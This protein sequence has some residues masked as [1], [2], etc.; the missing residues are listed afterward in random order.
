MDPD[1]GFLC[2]TDIGNAKDPGGGADHVANWLRNANTIHFIAAWEMRHNP[3]FN[4]VKFDGVKREAGRNAFRISA[5]EL[6]AAG[7]S[8]ILAKPDRYGGTYCTIDWAI[9]FTNW[10][11]PHFYVATIDCFRKLTDRLCGREELYQRF[12]RKLVI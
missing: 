2:V 6:A 10:L 4:A 3:T 12:Q 11:D 5:A 1:T 7:T 9:H 8:G